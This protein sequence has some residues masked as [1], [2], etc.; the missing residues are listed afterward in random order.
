[1][2]NLRTK[3]TE[4]TNFDMNWMLPGVHNFIAAV[5]CIRV[6][7]HSFTVSSLHIKFTRTKY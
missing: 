2:Y 6:I 3:Y 7:H 4:S 5:D 1:M